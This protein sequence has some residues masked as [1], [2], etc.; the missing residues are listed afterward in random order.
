MATTTRHAMYVRIGFDRYVRRGR[1]VQGG[2]CESVSSRECEQRNLGV[3]CLVSC[4]VVSSLLSG[5][6]SVS[7]PLSDSVPSKTPWSVG[8]GKV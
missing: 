7:C 6:L 2:G 1:T 4:R 3:E 5:V 8:E